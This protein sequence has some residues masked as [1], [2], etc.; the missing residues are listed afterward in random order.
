MVLI[1]NVF[2]IFCQK[3]RAINTITAWIK[4]FLKSFCSGFFNLGL[5]GNNFLSVIIERVTEATDGTKKSKE[6]RRSLY[7]F[8]QNH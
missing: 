5:M 6:L 4:L 1:S 3:D 7:V 2:G 8:H